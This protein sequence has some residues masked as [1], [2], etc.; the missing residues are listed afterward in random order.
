MRVTMYMAGG[1][2]ARTAGALG[3]QQA[4]HKVVGGDAGSSQGR[5]SQDSASHTQGLG[6]SSQKEQ[7]QL[8]PVGGLGSATLQNTSAPTDPQP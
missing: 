1:D 8:G 2:G 3:A 6:S 7:V 5:S 4:L